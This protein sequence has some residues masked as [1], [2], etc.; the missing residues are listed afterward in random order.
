MERVTIDGKEF[1]TNGIWKYKNRGVPVGQIGYNVHGSIWKGAAIEDGEEEFIFDCPRLVGGGSCI[2]LGDLNGGS[3]ILLAQGLQQNNLDGY[4]YTVDN[5][6]EQSKKNAIINMERAGVKDR[7]DILNMRTDETEFAGTYSFIFIDADHSYEGVRADFLS[8]STIL[9][10]DG[11][12]AFH[13]TNQTATN[14]V[15]EEFVTKDWELQF[16]VNRIKAF[17]RRHANAHYPL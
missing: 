5:Y 10:E 7:I 17:S 3:A 15:I 13:D 9:K 14:K 6:S 12:I 1:K 11:L 2:N 4:V 8:Y 16:W